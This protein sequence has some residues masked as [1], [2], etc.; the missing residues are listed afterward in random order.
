MSFLDVFIPDI[1]PFI[2]PYLQVD[3]QNGTFLFM[4]DPKSKW[5]H[6]LSH[7]MRAKWNPTKRCYEIPEDKLR[8][9]QLPACK[10]MTPAAEEALNRI[11]NKE[12]I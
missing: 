3:Y 6:R 2:E 7:K 1:L 4:C 10:D 11:Q 5:N 12:Q 9:N 8:P